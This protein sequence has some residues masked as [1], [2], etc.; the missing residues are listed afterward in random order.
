MNNLKELI[1]EFRKWNMEWFQYDLYKGTKPLSLEQFLEEL[2]K[3]YIV[4]KNE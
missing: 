2:N 1:T 3:K 4:T